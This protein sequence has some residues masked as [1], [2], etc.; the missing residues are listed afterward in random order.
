[1]RVHWC[2]LMPAFINEYGEETL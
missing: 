2:V 1:M